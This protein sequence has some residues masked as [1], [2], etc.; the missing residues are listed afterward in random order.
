MSRVT[1]LSLV[2]ISTRI[3]R[4]TVLLGSQA[5]QPSQSSPTSQSSQHSSLPKP[6][7]HHP[8]PTPVSHKSHPSSPSHSKPH[9]RVKN[10]IQVTATTII[11]NYVNF[12]KIN[13]LIFVQ[14]NK[15]V[16]TKITKLASC[17]LSLN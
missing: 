1:H 13:F 4:I 7:S 17:I 10:L 16:A 6:S 9:Y 8:W 11:H 12:N 15:N 14:C 2:T 5:S 3:T